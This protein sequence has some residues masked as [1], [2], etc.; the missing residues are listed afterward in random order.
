MFS[1]QVIAL[2]RVDS[3]AKT[4]FNKTNINVKIETK[5]WR[6]INESVIVEF[7]ITLD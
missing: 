6:L 4:L 5:Q 7:S 3:S 2:R 1:I